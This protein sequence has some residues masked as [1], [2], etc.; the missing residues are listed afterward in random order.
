MVK[1]D[2][3][4]CAGH[5]GEVKSLTCGDCCEKERTRMAARIIDLEKDQGR[6][7][8][9][10]DNLAYFNIDL[11]GNASLAWWKAE[12]ATWCEEEV[13]PKSAWRAAIDA[14]MSEDQRG[15]ET[16]RG[17]EIG[18]RVAAKGEGEGEG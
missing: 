13:E 8:W 12:W 18:P 10:K 2:F 11:D 9:M 1:M 6:L 3:V 5:G 17:I 15:E 16:G 7:E 14:A 4:H